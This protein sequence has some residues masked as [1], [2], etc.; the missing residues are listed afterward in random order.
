MKLRP[1]RPKKA[2]GVAVALVAASLLAASPTPASAAPSGP[3]VL[4]VTST[5]DPQYFMGR[6]H[7]GLGASATVSRATLSGGIVMTGAASQPGANDAF[8]FEIAPAT[9][10]QLRIGRYVIPYDPQGTN[11]YDVRLAVGSTGIDLVGDVEILDLAADAMGNVTR[12]DVVF[13]DRTESPTDALFGQIRMGQETDAGLIL[14]TTNIQYPNTPIG[15]VPIWTQ[16]RVTNTGTSSVPVGNPTVASGAVS[17]FRIAQDSCGGQTLAPG[18]T[19]TFDV[20]FTPTKAGPRA[21][22]VNVKT[23]TQTKTISVSGSAPRGSTYIKYS[24]DD[25]VSGGTVHAFPDG[26]NSNVVS[27]SPQTGWTFTPTRPYGLD[28]DAES[29][30]VRLV[31]YDYGQIKPGTYKTGNVTGPDAESSAKYGLLVT[32]NGRG[33]S[34]YTGR[35]TIAS[36]IVGSAGNLQTANISWTLQCKFQPGLMTGSLKWRDRIDKTA[37]APV[38]NIRVNSTNGVRTATWKGSS[39]TDSPNALARLSRA[40]GAGSISTSGTSVTRISATSA[41]LPELQA[42]H[43]YTLTVWSLDTAGNVGGKSTLTVI[44]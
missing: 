4:S 33:C 43:E 39:S 3:T 44:G 12:F 1:S 10:T 16:Q 5:S 6:Q 9:G 32:G 38:T 34:S 25:Y 24:G 14:G 20:G 19:C 2:F 37:P 41:V 15:S 7:S 11:A 8:T 27:G 35:V 30:S 28:N 31:K 22:T 18:A 26:V 40:E 23:G 17:D 42:G 29:T 36:F 13:R 21:G